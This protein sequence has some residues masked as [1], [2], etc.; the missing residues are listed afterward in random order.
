MSRLAATDLSA[1]KTNLS[2]SKR[3]LL[4]RRL[5]GLPKPAAPDTGIPRRPTPD[6]APLSS[7][8][9][10]M[11]FFYELQPTSA[12][13][14]MAYAFRLRGPLHATALQRALSRLLARHE[15]LRTRFVAE[16]GGPLQVVSPPQPLPVLEET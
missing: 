1:R 10:R 7:A 6:R 14:N 4:E 11:W 12:V 5:R 3:E 8:Q 13:Y 2:D 16:D 9:E 15:I